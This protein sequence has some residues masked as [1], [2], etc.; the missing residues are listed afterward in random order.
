[1]KNSMIWL[2]SLFFILFSS[3]AL[4]RPCNQYEYDK[5]EHLLGK[6]GEDLVRKFD[7]GRDIRVN[8]LSCEFNSYS[9]VFKTKISVYWNGKYISGNHY[10]IDGEVKMNSDGSGV[11]F[12][13]TYAN[14]AVKSL[15]FWRAAFAGAV[16]LSIASE[17]RAQ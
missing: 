10:N 3:S 17:N 13:E 15:N 6:A 7:G 5:A 11:E 1:M 14:D 2:I 8:I 12:S 16:I 9:D 4:S